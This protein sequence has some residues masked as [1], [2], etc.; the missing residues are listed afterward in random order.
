KYTKKVFNKSIFGTALNKKYFDDDTP[1]LNE[2]TI[3][4]SL[5]WKGA[6]PLKRNDAITYSIGHIEPEKFTLVKYQMV[7]ETLFESKAV[8][9]LIGADSSVVEIK[10]E[11][12]MIDLLSTILEDYKQK[13]LKEILDNVELPLDPKLLTEKKTEISEQIKATIN[14]INHIQASIEKLIMKLY[15]IEL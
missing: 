1:A 3:V 12:S 2:K 10:A 5:G 11:K 9:R 6:R 4:N 7:G 8:L 15:S 14:K 13:S